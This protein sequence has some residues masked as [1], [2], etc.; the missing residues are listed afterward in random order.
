[1][2]NQGVFQ[3]TKNFETN[4]SDLF[5]SS[6]QSTHAVEQ[7]SQPLPHEGSQPAFLCM[8]QLPYT[9]QTPHKTLT[10]QIVQLHGIEK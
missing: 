8:S 6:S 7:S 1:M 9:P 4:K 3:K 5:T 2:I 10:F